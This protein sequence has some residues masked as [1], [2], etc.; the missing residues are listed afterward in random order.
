MKLRL[1]RLLHGELINDASVA[2][3]RQCV[4]RSLPLDDQ[5]LKPVDV[6]TGPYEVI[7]D[8]FGGLLLLL[9]LSCDIFEFTSELNDLIRRLLSLLLPLF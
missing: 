5:L 6:V 2:I 3:G 1:K 8:V 7:V 9:M 4:G